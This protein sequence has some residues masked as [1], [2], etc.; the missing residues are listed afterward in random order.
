[1]G[2]GCNKKP[3]QCGP[4][5]YYEKVKF[6]PEDNKETL[7][8]QEY[9][10]AVK[11][12]NSWNVP[13][14]G[15]TA[16][17]DV[18]GLVSASLGSF[19]WNADFGYFEITGVNEGQLQVTN[20]C[21]L[22]NAVSGTQVPACSDF[23]VT[24]PP[25]DLI[26]NS[27]VYVKYDFTAPANNT[28]VDITVT[29]V[30][31]LVEGNEVQIGSGIYFLNSVN[32]NDIINI[33][34]YDNKGITPGTPVIAK[35]AGG[36]Y[37]YP[38]TV[39]SINPCSQDP[40]FEGKVVVCDGNIQK[41]LTGNTDGQF[42]TL[43]NHTT[44]EAG[45]TDGPCAAGLQTSGTVVICNGSSQAVLTGNNAGQILSLT[46]AATGEAEY[47]DPTA[48]DNWFN[49]STNFTGTVSVS[50]TNPVNSNVASLSI[51]N[52]YASRNQ[53]ILC[54]VVANI[55][56]VPTLAGS[57]FDLTAELQ[58]D[59]NGGGYN[60]VATVI[61]KIT[62]GDNYAFQVVHNLSYTNPPSTTSTIN[63]KLVITLAPGIAGDAFAFTTCQVNLN[64]L[65]IA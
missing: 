40:V 63:A 34:N 5:P 55:L 2:C 25:S 26:N 47:I 31:G 39:I 52:G 7:V 11:I 58:I 32:P 35:N 62:D 13:V 59:L 15:G 57:Y 19:L 6:C 3:C 33:C 37:Q 28:C 65:S 30:Q 60:T 56:G 46:N 51:A 29:S 14:C 24:D 18:N 50:G 64:A 4:Q 20:T 44:G 23:I 17:L 45:F 27:G 54:N 48:V 12:N 42:L 43:L 61:E 21:L 10:F 16:V 8:I 41:V 22:G 49:A 1:M 9:R 53:D 38:V 36:N